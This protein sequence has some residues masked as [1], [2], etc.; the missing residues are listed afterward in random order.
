MPTISNHEIATCVKCGIKLARY[1]SDIR[2][3]QC[4]KCECVVCGK[5]FNPPKRTMRKK[6]VE[7]HVSG[8]EYLSKILPQGTEHL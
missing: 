7:C 8:F 6:C 4:N 5:K 2:C 1:S 3:T